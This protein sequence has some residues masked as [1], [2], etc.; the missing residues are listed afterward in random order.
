[1]AEK[2][3]AITFG[4]DYHGTLIDDDKGDMSVYYFTE[5][6]AK[7]VV[8]DFQSIGLL[9]QCDLEPKDFYKFCLA[10]EK[11]FPKD[12]DITTVEEWKKIKQTFD[13]FK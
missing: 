8:D 7:I 12:I 3:F 10:Q 4:T 1:M 6:V 2:L 9:I 11:K 13:E 5:E